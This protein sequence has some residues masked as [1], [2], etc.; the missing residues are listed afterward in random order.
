VFQSAFDQNSLI[1][2]DCRMFFNV[3]VGTTFRLRFIV[4]RIRPISI[5]SNLIQ[6]RTQGINAFIIF[7]SELNIKKSN[8]IKIKPNR[9]KAEPTS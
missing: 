4:S 1:H 9:S 3:N 2:I 5:K 6:R 7:L 8:L